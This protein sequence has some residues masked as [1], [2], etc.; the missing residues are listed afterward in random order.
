MGLMRHSMRLSTWVVVLA[1]AL[2]ACGG[3]SDPDALPLGGE[4]LSGSVARV[5]VPEQARQGRNIELA[6]LSCGPALGHLHWTQIEGPELALLSARSPALSVEPLQAGAHR[7]EVRLQ[8]DQGHRYQ[9]QVAFTVAAGDASQPGLTVRGEPSV[10]AGGALSLRAWPQGLSP[11][12][13]DAATL[14]WTVIDGPATDL[15]KAQGW[16]LNFNAPQVDH[17]SLLRLRATLSLPDGRSAGQDFSLLVQ[18]PPHPAVNLLFVGSNAATRA[19]PYLENGPYAAALADCVYAPRLS[20]TNPNNLCDLTRL[21]LLGQATNGAM[22]SVEQ[23]MQRVVVS[24]DWMAEVFENFLR[25]QDSFGD[26]RRMLAAT[27]AIVIGGRVRPSYYWN[28]TGAIYL[29][30]GYLWLTPEQRDTV[31]EAS[32]PRSGFAGELN[33]SSPW[34]YVLNDQYAQ[35]SYPVHERKTRDIAALRYELG[36]LLYHELTHAA[37]FIPPRVHT[38]LRPDLHVYESSPALTASQDL[39]QRLPFF[40]TEMP[41]LAR[42]AFLGDAATPEQIAYTPDDVAGFFRIDRV[43]DDYSYTSPVGQGFSRED[44]AMLIEEAMMQLRYGVL[45]DHAFADKL[46]PGSHS[47]DALVHWGQRGRIGEAAIRPRLALVLAEVM[48]WVDTAALDH[49]APPLALSAGRTWG[50]NLDQAALA[51]GRSRSLSAQERRTE[52]ELAD[53][54]RL[55]RMLER[56]LRAA[57]ADSQSR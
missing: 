50:D 33:Y 14:T 45:R 6:V 41:G 56:R 28:V 26:F 43:N 29:D 16:A 25:T 3:G 49:L 15:A 7:F 23:V 54:H 13:Q 17:D 12:E 22:P 19:Y 27:T 31:S 38:L 21:P 39:A 34:R 48:P 44:P 36:W 51:A 40:S 2:T 8:D 4:C 5:V 30:A 55:D 37:D 11:A 42:V 18:P 57:Q 10:W 47:A 24:N 20:W 9:G 52:A 32:D 1:V 46:Q 53:R 35:G